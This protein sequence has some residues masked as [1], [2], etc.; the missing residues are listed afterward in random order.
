MT[1][2]EQAQEKAESLKPRE[3]DTVF[4]RR[5]GVKGS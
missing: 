2:V 3:E 5:G 4:R 1:D